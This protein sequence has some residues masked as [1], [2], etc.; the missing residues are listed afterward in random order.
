MSRPPKQAKHT[1]G[2]DLTFLDAFPQD[3]P[4]WFSLKWHGDRSWAINNSSLRHYSRRANIDNDPDGLITFITDKIGTSE[5]NVALDVAAGSNPQALRD[6]LDSGVVGRALATNYQDRRPWAVRRDTRL[7]HIKGTLAQA[8]TWRKIIDW[9]RD[10]APDGLAIAMHRPVGGLQD[11]QPEVYRGAAH[12]L[13]DMVRPGGIMF[14][15]VPRR[16]RNVPGQ[17]EELCGSL[18]ERPDVGGI[19]HSAPRPRYAHVDESDTYAVIIKTGGA[20]ATKQ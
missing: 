2:P 11:L 9:Q 19:I 5:D 17:L 16:L 14:T 3:D 10:H 15:Q 6:L 20:P 1:D 4:G 12:V 7:D 13:F 8:D 18:R